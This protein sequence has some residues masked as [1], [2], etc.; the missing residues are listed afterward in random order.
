MSK[1]TILV[2]WAM[3]AEA[4]PFLKFF[5]L[6][7]IESPEP[8]LPIR[9][10]RGQTQHFDVVALVNGLDPR[11]EVDRVGPT[12]AAHSAL[13]GLN[14]YR[15]D[16][17]M[18][19]G[20]AGAF[21]SEGSG[22]A[23][24]YL[25]SGEFNYHDRLIPIPGFDRY[26]EGHYPAPRVDAL[27]E[28]LGFKVGGISTGSSLSTH[29]DELARIHRLGGRIKEMEAAAIAELCEAFGVPL[30]AVKSVTDLLDG[31][32]PAQ[33]QFVQNLGRASARLQEALHQI[34]GCS[35]LISLLKG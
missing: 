16:L 10:Y 27:A 21:A 8:K 11:H 17:V 19:A 20:T 15:P 33:E 18:S 25:G 29:E 31:A 13:L 3:H 7:A 5:E 12:P 23:D 24:I 22:I 30:L 4:D 28:R 34:L 2:L 9:A 1:P 32:K 35:D 6:D 26:G 14:H